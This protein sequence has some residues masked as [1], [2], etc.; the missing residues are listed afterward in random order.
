MHL[1]NC[2]RNRVI[3][4][5]RLNATTC[6]LALLVDSPVR[7]AIQRTPVDLFLAKGARLGIVLR[8]LFLKYSDPGPFNPCSTCL[9][10]SGLICIH[11]FPSH[12]AYRRWICPAE[13]T[14]ISCSDFS[15][16]YISICWHLERAGAMELNK[17][18]PEYNVFI[19]VFYAIRMQ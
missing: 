16:P 13:V 19:M 2:H 3:Q 15:S 9:T 6:Q 18:R 4:H 14:V 7:L 17:S 5:E 12:S 11:D 8:S 1:V 10:T